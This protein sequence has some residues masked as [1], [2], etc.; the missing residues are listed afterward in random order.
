MVVCRDEP[1]LV[2]MNCLL[3]VDDSNLL[4]GCQ[5]GRQASLD[6]CSVQVTT[7]VW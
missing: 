1:Q 3:Y 2:G 5:S 6:L 7:E 4:V